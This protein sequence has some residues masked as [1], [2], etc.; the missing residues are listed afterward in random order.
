MTMIPV[1]TK[2]R[3]NPMSTASFIMCIQE[4]AISYHVIPIRPV[5]TVGPTTI[6]AI[7]LVLLSM[8]DPKRFLFLQTWQTLKDDCIDLCLFLVCL[9]DPIIIYHATSYFF[10]QNSQSVCYIRRVH[11]TMFLIGSIGRISG[12]ILHHLSSHLWSSSCKYPCQLSQNIN[13]INIPL[14]SSREDISS[15]RSTRLAWYMYN[16]NN[17]NI[18]TS[19][20]SWPHEQQL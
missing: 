2:T 15:A 18:S 16:H 20:L 7:S 3:V 5:P 11:I 10:L 9:N 17:N 1:G 4:Y 19:S 13:I 14:Y 12:T 6:W 8:T